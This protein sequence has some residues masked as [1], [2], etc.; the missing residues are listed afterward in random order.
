MLR[1]FVE[2]KVRRQIVRRSLTISAL[3]FAAILAMWNTPALS[4]LMRPLRM[5]TNNIHGGLSAFAMQISGGSVESFT[6]SEAGAYTLLFQDGAE[7]LIMSAGYLGSALLG[8][9][10]FYLVNRAPH[11]LRG[12]SILLGIFT[13]GF[14]AL[15]I[16]PD[17]AGDWLSMLVCMGFGALLIFLGLT[18]TGDINQLRSRKSI[19]QVVLSIIALM[20]TLHIVLD[21]PAVLQVPA[22]SGDTIT[23]P[24]AYFADY[25]MPGASVEMVAYSWSAIAIGLLGIACNYAIIRP[26]RQIPKNDDIV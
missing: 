2:R 21:L 22:M 16:R 3:G 20:T 5:F 11:L 4:G 1:T 12:L 14:L 6:L 24:V 19:T 25:V 9:L 23:N 8:A 15:F 7:A 17:V 10:L 18:G 13:I 26:L